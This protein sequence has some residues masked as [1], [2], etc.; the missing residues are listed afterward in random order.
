MCSL[1]GVSVNLNTPTIT[2]CQVWN[3]LTYMSHQQNQVLTIKFD[4]H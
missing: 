3:T 2:K 1:I 4:V